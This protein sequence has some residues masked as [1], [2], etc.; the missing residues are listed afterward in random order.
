MLRLKKNPGIQFWGLWL[1]ATTAGWAAAFAVQKIF[2][3]QM[4]AALGW[5]TMMYGLIVFSIFMGNGLVIGLL[6]WLVLRGY[7][8]SSKWWI[9]AAA[10]GWALSWSLVFSMSWAFLLTSNPPSFSVFVWLGGLAGGIVGGFIQMFILRGGVRRMMLWIGC[11]ML[12]TPAA[13]F[14]FYGVELEEVFAGVT[15]RALAGGLTAGALSGL[16]L[17]LL[18][19]G[20]PRPVVEL[21]DTRPQYKSP[22]FR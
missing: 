10:P 20:T 9:P 8:R 11:S 1:L 21:E 7:L 18:L 13:I 4:I 12:F 6:Q 16:G 5:G 15:T 2:E 17:L 14:A 3:D 19:R 22:D